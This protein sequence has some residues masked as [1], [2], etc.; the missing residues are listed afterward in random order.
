MSP[1]RGLHAFVGYGSEG[2]KQKAFAQTLLAFNTIDS[3]VQY[4]VHKTGE[5]P[6]AA[7]LRYN[8]E[9]DFH[10]V[11][12]QVLA[13]TALRG[14]DACHVA[15]IDALATPDAKAVAE[16]AAD[17]IA[18]TFDCDKDDPHTGRK[19]QK[20]DVSG[21]AFETPTAK[22]QNS[23]TSPNSPLLSAWT[24]P[25][26]MPPFADIRPEH[27]RPAFTAVFAAH[28]AEID[29]IAAN[30]A[31]PDFEN[32]IAALERA[33]RMLQRV[34]AVFFNLA[35]ADA[36][37]ELQAIEREIAPRY[38]AHSQAIL[39]N[40]ALFARVD[41]LYRRR[42][43]LGLTPEQ[44]R[45]LEDHHRGFVRAGA[46]LDEA[47]RRRMAEIMER[48]ADLTTRFAQNVLADESSYMLVLDSEQDLAGLPG[49]LRAS[50]AATAKERGADGKYAIT[51]SRSSIEPFLQFSTRRDLREQ[52][53]KAWIARGANGGDGDNRALITE[54]LALRAEQ[55]TL[56]GFPDF[57]AFKLDDTM[58]KTTA[59]VRDLLLAVWEPARARAGAERDA[60]AKFASG[61]G[62]FSRR[63]VGLALLCREGPQGST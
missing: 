35:S 60:L 38:A 61:G 18:T 22:R 46:Q 32:T 23:M 50:A 63:R 12:G 37:P 21:P 56:L 6:Y 27:Y 17:T 57:T 53:F 47:G 40:G 41:A 55:A 43:T 13:V 5:P 10:V 31:E 44:K 3:V 28:N 11:K 7:I 54:T 15:Y 52:A 2:L 51:L 1:P 19:R 62:E 24:A 58:A 29:A 20:P 9:D 34:G 4:R 59:A 42:D 8:T 26:E 48:L 25:Y 14:S 30:A 49:F 39:T 36:S 33:G 16:R 45:V